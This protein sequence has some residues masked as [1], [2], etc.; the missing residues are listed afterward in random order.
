MVVDS[1]LDEHDS[2]VS[3]AY[4]KKLGIDAAKQ[5]LI[6]VASHWHD[7]HVHGLSAVVTVQAP[8]G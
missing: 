3:L 7:D 2:P 1:C 6:V 4:L 8:G 5:V